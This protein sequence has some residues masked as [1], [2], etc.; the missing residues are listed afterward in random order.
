M[1]NY[2]SPAYMESLIGYLGGISHEESK[3]G[4]HCYRLESFLGK[5]LAA[6]ISVFNGTARVLGCVGLLLLSNV[7]HFDRI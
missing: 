3:N 7:R 1:E 2:Y 6:E 5:A 4:I